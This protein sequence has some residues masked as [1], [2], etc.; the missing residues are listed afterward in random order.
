MAE[1]IYLT[2]A[3]WLK[4][5]DQTDLQ[6]DE[7]VFEA[8]SAALRDAGV[9]RHQVDLSITSSLDLYDG[10]SISTALTA[11]AAAGYLGEETRV[12][13]DASAAFL[14]AASAIASGQSDVAVVVASNAPEVG[15]TS[16][17]DLRR[18]R[19]QVSSYTFDSHFDRPV[20]MSSAVTLG[21][22]AARSLD[23]GVATLDDLAAWTA[24]DI[25][26]GLTSGRSSRSLVD[27]A[28]VLASQ[29]YAAP[30]T[31]LML[32]AESAGVGVLVLAGGVMGRRSPR[33]RARLAGWG[34]VTGRATTS[35]QWLRDPAEASG[36]AAAQAFV[37]AGIESGA[38]G[39]AE[40][41]DLAPSLTAPLRKA[42]GI[43]HLP[44]EKVNRTG[45]ARSAHPGIASGLLRLIEAT[46][47]LRDGEADGSPAL[48]HTTDDLMGLVSA[49]T[50]VTVL[51]AM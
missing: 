14:V 23:T 25:E 7:A 18:I 43:G 1:E 39:Y 3:A 41:T 48:V 20:G 2:G 15:S 47:A 32:P 11:G 37:R 8:T 22:H 49:T 9:K 13:G 29:M 19:E 16:E 51:E 17:A 21:L 38:I 45:G 26:R 24:R 30:L 44:V 36:R 42:L 12:E 10:R 35:P 46:E 5:E 40:I 33:A 31:D 34:S 4:L 6:L 28:G 50:S 27:A